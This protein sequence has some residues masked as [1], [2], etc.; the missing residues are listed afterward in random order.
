L[1]KGTVDSL[2]K[3]ENKPQLTKILTYHV[4]PGRLDS[5]ALDK[6][7]RSGGGQAMLKTVEGETL[8]ARGS[9]KNFTVTDEK[10]DTAKVTIPDVYQKN[11]MIMVINKVLLPK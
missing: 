11:G 10:G 9:G 6:D 1:P 4:V 5:K 7:I 8:I 3:P 2:L